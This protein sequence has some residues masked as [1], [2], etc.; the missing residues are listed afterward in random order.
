M[1]KANYIEALKE[2]LAS[3]TED[4]PYQRGAREALKLALEM[5]ETLRAT[6][7]PKDR[8]VSLD[9]WE[10]ATCA[11]A[12]TKLEPSKGVRELTAKLSVWKDF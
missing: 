10:C 12:L 6:R 3:L 5:A 1:T 4:T 11:Y 7:R 9:K 2:Q 8:V